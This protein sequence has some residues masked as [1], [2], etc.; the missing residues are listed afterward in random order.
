MKQAINQCFGSSGLTD[1]KLH[2]FAPDGTTL[3]AAT[4]A[5]VYRLDNGGE[6]SASDPAAAAA[7]ICGQHIPVPD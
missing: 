5:V 3:K 7:A 6:H 2:I 1:P 4:D